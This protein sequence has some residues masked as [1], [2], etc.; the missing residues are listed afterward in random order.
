MMA[1]ISARE[2]LFFVVTG[3]AE[4]ML[5][6]LLLAT[7]RMLE[8][9]QAGMATLAVKIGM[10]AACPEMVVFFAA[11]YARQRHDLL[12]IERQLNFTQHG[13]LA[14]GKLGRHAARDAVRAAALS[15]GCS[16]LGACL[17]L[18]AASALPHIR[19]CL[20]GFGLALGYATRSCRMCWTVGLA[21]C[22]IVLAVLGAWL[23]V[24]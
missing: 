7:T 2:R 15:A 18:L 5:T 16:F 4:G 11:E 12:R 23:H 22:G 3:L 10:V 20:S 1:W 9:A 13:V 19:G 14:G 8:P 6:A 24:V 17:P 21:G